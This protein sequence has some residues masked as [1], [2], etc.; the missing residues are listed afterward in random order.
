L[1]LVSSGKNYAHDGWQ[2][3]DALIEPFWL[4]STVGAFVV[5]ITFRSLKRYSRILHVEGR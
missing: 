4:W 3:W 5:F 1:A 2:G